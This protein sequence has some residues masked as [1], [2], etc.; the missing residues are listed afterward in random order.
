MTISKSKIGEAGVEGVASAPAASV[1]EGVAKVTAG[2]E[3]TQARFTLGLEKAMKTAEE[4]VAF[5]QGN[6]EALL[7]SSQILATGVQDL[8]RH[9]AASAQASLDEGFSAFK[10]L[11]GIRSLKDAFELQSSF[12]RAAVEKSLAESGKLTDASLK[13]TEQALAPLAARVTVAVERFAK[14]A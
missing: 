4:L 5:N 13:L 8:S 11:T 3:A 9:F 14:P 1:G 7:K 2:F 12:T 10:A 6:A